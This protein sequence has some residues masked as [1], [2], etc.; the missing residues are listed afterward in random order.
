MIDIWSSIPTAG[1]GNFVFHTAS[2]HPA[3]MGTWCTD[4]R[5]DQQLQT[6]LAPTLPGEM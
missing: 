6:A 2:V 5:L 3:I 1:Q 4:V